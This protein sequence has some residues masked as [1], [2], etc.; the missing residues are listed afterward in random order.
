MPI[1][2]EPFLEYVVAIDNVAYYPKTEALFSEPRMVEPFLALSGQWGADLGQMP[3]HATEASYWVD[4]RSIRL[5][6]GHASCPV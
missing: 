1:P 4:G 2:L 6:H 5:L 3:R